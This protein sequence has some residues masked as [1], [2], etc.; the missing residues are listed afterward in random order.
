MSND[1]NFLI[2]SIFLRFFESVCILSKNVFWVC[3]SESLTSYSAMRNGLQRGRLRNVTCMQ[4]WT[5]E[6]S[7]H[8]N[9]L[10]RR[11]ESK[12][13]VQLVW[14]SH[15]LYTTIVSISN[16]HDICF[17]FPAQNLFIHHR[18]YAADLTVLHEFTRILL[19]FKEYEK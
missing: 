17:T 6:D 11:A 7:R 4:V 14:Q 3:G 16:L 2:Q 12:D 10:S 15:M 18:L 8:A 1:K 9:F 19:T 5:E 13:F